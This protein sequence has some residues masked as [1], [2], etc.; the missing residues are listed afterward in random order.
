MIAAA[1]LLLAS[2]S[3]GKKSI[4]GPQE[5]GGGEILTYE[6]AERAIN[7]M[8]ST[9]W[10]SHAVYKDVEQFYIRERSSLGE[11]DKLALKRKLQQR[12]AEQL[13]RTIDHIL[14][15][16]CSPRHTTMFSAVR[17]LYNTDFGG[18]VPA[19]R[20]AVIER[21]DRH[22]E[23]MKFVISP[24]YDAHLRSFLDGYDDSYD[25]RKRAE[26]AAIRAT[27]PTCKAIL[28][29]V[30]E[31]AVDAAIAERRQDY[32]TRLV[33]MFCATEDI[34]THEYQQLLSKVS[35]APQPARLKQRIEAHWRQINAAATA[36]ADE[37]AW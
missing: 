30:S 28:G 34:T 6:A 19:S 14:A 2:C 18:Y 3:G 13:T 26:A 10:E 1:L 15:S 31:S 27:N 23:Q 17:T 32:F 4:D 16:D 9:D 8:D 25:R 29:R 36:P 21:F 33:N 5:E 7:S 20:Q 22:E 12:Y 24:H 37:P 11:S 35:A